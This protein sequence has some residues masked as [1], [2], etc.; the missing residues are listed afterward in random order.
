MSF[1]LGTRFNPMGIWCS[2][3]VAPVKY[4]GNG[5]FTDSQTYKTDGALLGALGIV[6]L[7]FFCVQCYCCCLPLY[8]TPEAAGSSS[9]VKVEVKDKKKKKD[10]K[11]SG[12]SS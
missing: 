9:T 12:S 8:W 5:K 7:F 3:N 1:A 2:M 11:G 6:Q 4:E 10:K